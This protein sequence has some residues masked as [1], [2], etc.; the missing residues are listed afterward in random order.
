VADAS[1]EHLEDLVARLERER[2]AADRAYNDAL[3]ALDR[4]LQTSAPP[5][6]P[7]PPAA[8]GETPLRPPTDVAT[9]RGGLLQRWGARLLGPQFAAQSAFN[10]A[11]V[12]R[13]DEIAAS[14]AALRGTIA[15]LLDAVRDR[16][17]QRAALDSRLI[18]YLQTITAFVDSKD[19]SL[20]GPEIRAR[21]GVVEQRLMAMKREIEQAG[22]PAGPAAAPSRDDAFAGGI[23][24]ATYSAFEDRFRG[25]RQEIRTRLE[26][27]LPLLTATSDVVDIG[28]GRG[29]LLDLLKAHNV[30]ARGVDTNQ[31]MVEECRG[32]GLRVEQG[33]ALGFLKHQQ[34]GSIGGL[35]AIQVVEHFEP[36]YL[37]RFI[38]AAFHSMRPGAPLVLETINPACWMAFFETYI[39][40]LTHIRP[41]HPDTLKYLVEASGFQNVEV[42]FRQPV[43]EADRLQRASTVTAGESPALAAIAAT[44]DDH[45]DKLN[46]RLFSSMDYALVARR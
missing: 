27:Y 4:A 24:S 23:D 9:G 45:A 2:A 22:R 7:P 21:L 10:A 38:E 42:R 1:P 35:V 43:R 6:P 34:D 25:A 8:A 44:L 28:C 3:T 14:D 11:V 19:R 32:R 46:A 41:L 30:A 36:G 39:R 16:F 40:D 5:L 12:A 29:E 26:D 17:D 18:L 33:D 20:S 31:A 37:M 15:R 13:L